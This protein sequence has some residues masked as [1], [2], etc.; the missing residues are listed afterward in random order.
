[1]LHFFATAA[2]RLQAYKDL[3]GKNFQPEDFVYLAEFNGHVFPAALGIQERSLWRNG[4]GKGKKQINIRIA[5]MTR[6]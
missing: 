6:L 4:T 3:E 5:S 1:M 2:Y